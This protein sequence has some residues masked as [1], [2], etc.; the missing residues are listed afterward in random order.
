GRYS[1]LQGEITIGN[2]VMIGPYCLIYTCNH[3]TK[4]LSVPMFKQGMDV[5]KPVVIE[6]DVWIGG[7]VII[8][9]G[10]H[11]GTGAIIGAGAVVTKDVPEYAIVAGNPAKIIRY[12]SEI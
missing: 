11:I 4:D 3:N 7:R 8:L 6:D 1:M 9:P 10:V 12:R 2:G 5:M